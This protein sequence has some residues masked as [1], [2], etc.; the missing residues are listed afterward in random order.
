MGF[1]NTYGWEY[2][3]GV[4]IFDLGWVKKVLSLFRIVQMIRRWIRIRLGMLKMCKWMAF[5][6]VG[7]LVAKLG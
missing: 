5:M 2:F 3:E 7:E 6:R 4:E 1:I